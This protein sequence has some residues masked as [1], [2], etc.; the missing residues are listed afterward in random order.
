MCSQTLVKRQRFVLLVGL[1]SHALWLPTRAGDR[2]K[3][4]SMQINATEKKDKL[5]L[6]SLGWKHVKPF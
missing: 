2:M 3:I 4:C 5:C 6:G 1:K